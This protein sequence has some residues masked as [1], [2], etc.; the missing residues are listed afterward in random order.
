MSDSV[1]L[2]V[3]VPCFNEEANIPELAERVLGVLGLA[4]LRGEIVLV[5]DGSRDATASVIREQMRIHG[6]RVVGCFHEHNQGLA[7]AWRTGVAAAHGAHVAVIDAD[8]QYQP[9]DIVRLYTALLDSSVDIVQGWRST[10]GR[11]RGGRYV[12]SRGL[13]AI[14]N[15]AFGMDLRDNKSGFLCCSREVMADILVHRGR[16]SYWQSFIMVAA[17]ARGYSYREIETLFLDRKQGKSFLEGHALRASVKNFV[18]VG[19]AFWEYRLRPQPR[20]LSPLLQRAEDR[21]PVKNPIK[22]RARFATATRRGWSRGRSFE[23]TYETLDATQWLPPEEI[24]ELQDQKLRRLVRHAYRNVPYYRARMRELKL[25]PEDIR[26]QED[27]RKLPL[28]SKD[29]VRKHLYFDIIQEDVSPADLV[30]ISTAGNS[31]EPLVCYVEAAQLEFRVAA[32]LRGR[33]WTGYRFG[34]PWVVLSHD[35][36]IPHVM[37]ER[38]GAWLSGCEVVSMSGITESQLSRVA[39][40]ISAKRPTLI[41]GDAELL[42]LLAGRVTDLKGPW[43]AIASSGQTLTPKA[44][45]SIESAFGCPVFDAYGSREFARLAHEAGASDVHHVAGEGFIVEVLL[46]GRPVRPGEVGEVVITDLNGYAMP[47]LRYRI[48]DLAELAPE[49]DRDARA[50][51]L[52][53]IGQI[54]GRV[55]SILRGTDDRFVPGTLLHRIAGDYDFAITRLR[56]AQTEPGAITLRI[57]KGRRYADETLDEIRE[58]LRG[59]LGRDLR[60]DV[61]FEERSDD[62][63]RNERRDPISTRPVDFQ[64][65]RGLRIGR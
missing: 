21:A 27:L 28:L 60:I 63:P 35:P 34:D 4:G 56:A 43:K 13:N 57:I 32:E 9:E 62:Q 40:R 59:Y 6:E 26:T 7:A 49:P 25:A 52:P 55:Q 36:G 14:L 10:V 2:S 15:R 54:H 12:L 20:A 44:R 3:V 5:D 33:E 31:G 23:R 53:R 11:T 42:E 47:L 51:G 41:E 58:R 18:D 50:R 1:E 8:L 61:E 38:L 46:E 22:L 16:Y 64:R 17:H 48:G 30:R 37:R 29:D 19:T 45:A 24:R 39:D 65:S